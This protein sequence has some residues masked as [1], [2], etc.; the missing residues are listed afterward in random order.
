MIHASVFCRSHQQSKGGDGQFDLTHGEEGSYDPLAGIEGG[1][2]PLF[3]QFCANDPDILLE[4]AKK[5]QHRCDAVDINLS[6]AE[7]A[8]SSAELIFIVAAVPKASPSVVIME[9]FFR[10]IGKPL[11]A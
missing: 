1:D 10:T 6:A 2:R 4:A 7:N 8:E 9:R 3:V 11:R 5:V